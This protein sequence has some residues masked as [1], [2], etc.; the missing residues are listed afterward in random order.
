[1][2]TSRTALPLS[3][4]VCSGE[5]LTIE[6]VLS[7]VAG[8]VTTMVNPVSEMAYVEY[9]PAL[10]DP[11]ALFTVLQRGGFAPSD[12]VAVRTGRF[13]GGRMNQIVPSPGASV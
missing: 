2:P 6:R 3:S 1:M 5:R 4:N 10:T 13:Q 11:A 8:V 12:R 9:D 7:E